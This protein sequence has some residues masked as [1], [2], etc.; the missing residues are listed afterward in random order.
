MTTNYTL[1]ISA[2]HNG[3][4]ALDHYE[5]LLPQ[6]HNYLASQL[7]FCTFLIAL[8]LPFLWRRLPW[9]G[10]FRQNIASNKTPICFTKSLQSSKLRQIAAAGP[11]KSDS[12]Q[13]LASMDA[14]I[15]LTWL[16]A[17]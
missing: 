14:G 1:T 15:T 10:I 3:R 4:H 7:L 17:D 2:I 12:T 16:Y 13:N 5:V 9:R 6:A 11:V 8:F